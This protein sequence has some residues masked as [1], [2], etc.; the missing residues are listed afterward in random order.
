MESQIAS[1]VAVITSLI[2]I[3]SG[4]VT[5]STKQSA[6]YQG[7]VVTVLKEQIASGEKR[8]ASLSADNKE[9]ALTITKLGASVDKLTEQGAQTVRLLEDMVY[10][11]QQAQ[12]RRNP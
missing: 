7:M 6:T 12:Q 10:G 5:Y 4:M 2:A 9:Q 11:R 8:E 3:V 1:L